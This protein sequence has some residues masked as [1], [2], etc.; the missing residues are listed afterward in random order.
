MGRG[1]GWEEGGDGRRVG[2]G[3]GWGW[4]WKEGG[5][6][7]RVGMGGGW[8]WKDDLFMAIIYQWLTVVNI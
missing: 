4:G 7:R 3:G 6:G 1:W 5:D 8:G 2:M